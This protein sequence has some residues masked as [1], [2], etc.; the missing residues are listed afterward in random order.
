ME[1]RGRAVDAFYRKHSPHLLPAEF[2]PAEW[3]NPFERFDTSVHPKAERAHAAAREWVWAVSNGE[4]RGLVLWSSGYGAGKTMLAEMAAECLTVMRDHQ[5]QAQKATLLTAPEFFQTIKD[6]YST[7]DPVGPIFEKWCQGHFLL[8]DWGKHYTTTSGEEW[9]REQFFRLIN[10]IYRQHG[11]MLTSNVAPE[12]IEQQIGG[13]AFSRLLGM[14]GPGGI[15]DLNGVPD[16]RL[17]RA[18]F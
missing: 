13:A 8:D 10:T 7:G 14:C 6:V 3:Q 5:G 1:A 17:K 2:D 16:Y 15:L 9:A 18:G 4:A 12:V 11:F